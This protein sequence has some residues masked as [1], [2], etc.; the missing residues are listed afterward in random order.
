MNLVCIIREICNIPEK[1][2]GFLLAE[3]EF[4]FHVTQVQIASSVHAVNILSVLTFCDAFFYVNY[5]Y[6]YSMVSCAM[7]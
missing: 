2:T 4:F 1:I 5:Y 7:V 3:N 6:C